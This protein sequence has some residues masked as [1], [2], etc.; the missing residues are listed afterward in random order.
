MKVGHTLRLI[1]GAVAIGL[2]TVVVAQ[3]ETGGQQAGPIK[4]Y[5]A[6]VRESPIGGSSGGGYMKIVNTGSEPDRLIGA[7]SPVSD[8][9]VLNEM[10]HVGDRFLMR[11]VDNGIVIPAGASVRLRL[12]S[13]LLLFVGLKEPFAPDK[14]FEVSLNFEKAGR[15]TVPF[16]VK[17]RSYW[18]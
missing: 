4:I 9:I 8:K 12:E 10:V 13:Y 16:E 2:A 14:N 1:C 15:V 6:W 7:Q 5:D 3:A 17:P 11:T 18:N